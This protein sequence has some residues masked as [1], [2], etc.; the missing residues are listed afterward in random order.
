MWGWGSGVVFVW[1]DLNFGTIL[2]YVMEMI[3]VTVMFLTD[4]NHTEWFNFVG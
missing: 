2:G 3:F 1:L 4:M